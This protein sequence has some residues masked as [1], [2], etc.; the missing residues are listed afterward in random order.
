VGSIGL[1]HL[2]A[3]IF[4]TCSRDLVAAADYCVDLSGVRN[5]ASSCQPHHQP[6]WRAP[7]ACPD[8]VRGVLEQAVNGRPAA[9]RVP[10]V[11]GEVFASVEDCEKRLVT[12]G[13]V[14]G[15]DVVVGHSARRPGNEFTI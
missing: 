12:L 11:T 9:W 7:E 2:L 5:S 8:R 14:E 13:L 3:H 6:L 10:P 15:F 1:L 4:H